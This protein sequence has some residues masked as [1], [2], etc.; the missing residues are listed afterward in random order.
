MEIVVN[1]LKNADISKA[2][3]INIRESTEVRVFSDEQQ[4]MYFIHESNF[5]TTTDNFKLLYYYTI[6]IYYVY[7]FIASINRFLLTI[8]NS[9]NVC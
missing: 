4:L 7:L 5:V 2:V 1:L 9:H 6:L 8:K 3:N